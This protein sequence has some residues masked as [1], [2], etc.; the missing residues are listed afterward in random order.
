M[1]FFVFGVDVST[2][3]GPFSKVDFIYFVWQ[4]FER[5][6]LK[7]YAITLIPSE[8]ASLSTPRGC[9]LKYFRA[10][11]DGWKDAAICD[12]CVEQYQTTVRT[13]RLSSARTLLHYCLRQ[14][15]QC[16]VQRYTYITN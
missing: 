5:I 12:T 8:I 4:N 11:S 15:L 16:L 1:N 3:C 7:K 2:R 13:E 9:C 10:A 6:Y 14:P